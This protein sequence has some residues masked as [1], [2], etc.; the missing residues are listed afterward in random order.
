MHEFH[1]GVEVQQTGGTP[2][3]PPSGRLLV[4][5]LHSRHTDRT[6]GR[7]RTALEDALRR[8]HEMHPLWQD[9]GHVQL[10]GLVDD[11]AECAV[12]VA[13]EQVDD[14]VGE[15]PGGESRSADEQVAG[16]RRVRQ[17]HGSILAL[18]QLIVSGQGSSNGN[19]R[20]ETK[21]HMV[22]APRRRGD[23]PDF[24][25]KVHVPGR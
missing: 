23:E 2:D 18:D 6:V 13:V 5:L 4:G 14:A 21:P 15:N 11:D 10:G 25:R 17:N 7:D 20:N 1:R 3:R 22:G 8:G 16:S 12:L 24:A 19:E 9:L